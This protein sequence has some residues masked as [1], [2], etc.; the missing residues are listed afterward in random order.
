ML[1]DAR[2]YWGQQND[3]ATRLRVAGARW[4]HRTPPRAGNLRGSA[5]HGEE[6]PEM[7]SFGEEMAAQGKTASSRVLRLRVKQPGSRAQQ[8]FALAAGPY[9]SQERLLQLDRAV[10]LLVIKRMSYA[11]SD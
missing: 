4:A 7:R 5:P 2:A 6:L 9:A 8:F 3:A 11:A 10:A 1:L